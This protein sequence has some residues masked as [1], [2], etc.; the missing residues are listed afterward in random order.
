MVMTVFNDRYSG[1]RLAHVKCGA[2]ITCCLLTSN[3]DANGREIFG[4]LL[5]CT[6]YLIYRYNGPNL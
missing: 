6:D 5:L 3:V 2:I 4:V 1:L